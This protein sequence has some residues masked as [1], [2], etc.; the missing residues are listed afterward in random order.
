MSITRSETKQHHW[1]KHVIT[2]VA[3][4][5]GADGEPVVFV[6]PDQQEIAEQDAVYGCDNCSQP[7]ATHFNTECEGENYVPDPRSSE[8]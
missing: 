1:V 3:V 8:G 2:P 4:L 6:D 7:M 5:S